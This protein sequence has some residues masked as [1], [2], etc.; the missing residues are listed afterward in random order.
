MCS[1]SFLCRVW[2]CGTCS[3]SRKEGRLGKSGLSLLLL[4][5]RIQGC[6]C[7]SV[8]VVGVWSQKED[9]EE[10][11][12]I[13]KQASFLGGSIATCI[14]DMR[15]CR[16]FILSFRPLFS[17]REKPQGGGLRARWIGANTEIEM[18]AIAGASIARL[19]C[20]TRLPCHRPDD[21]I[22]AN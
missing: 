11:D 10:K 12:C 19:M 14:R 9:D 22:Y 18:C 8:S 6:C 13:P 16:W 20:V 7:A 2:V 15:T 5:A 4:L 17:A 3:R 1:F 21:L